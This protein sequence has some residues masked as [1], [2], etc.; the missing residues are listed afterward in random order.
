M[1]SPLKKT[2]L[3]VLILTILLGLTACGRQDPGGEE[4]PAPP[5]SAAPA[6]PTP[7]KYLNSFDDASLALAKKYFDF[8]AYA[9]NK[10]RVKENRINSDVITATVDGVELTLGMP[11][12]DVLAAG[13]QPVD[14]SSAEQKITKKNDKPIEFTSP[15]GLIVTLTFAG[16]KGKPVTDGVLYRISMNSKKYDNAAMLLLSGVSSDTD[17]MQSMID[18]FGNKPSRIRTIAYEEG[19]MLS[20]T[21]REQAQPVYINFAVDPA[22]E[23]IYH[24]S[25]EG[26]VKP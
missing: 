20:V 13:F 10:G 4:T 25:I 12:A 16:E 18:T 5:A 6:E 3:F 23:S 8:D 17:T 22:D 26:N 24:I 14:E 21:Y 11:Y 19:K 15:E 2:V 9:E 7:N 1:T